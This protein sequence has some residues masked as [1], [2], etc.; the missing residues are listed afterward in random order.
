MRVEEIA[1]VIVTE[2][3]SLIIVQFAHCTTWEFSIAIRVPNAGAN[4]C[5]F[6]SRINVAPGGGRIFLALEQRRELAAA[7]EQVWLDRPAEGY[8]LERPPNW[9]QAQRQALRDMVDQQGG[10]T[11]ALLRHIRQSR[12]SPLVSIDTIKRYVKK[13][14][15]AASAVG[16]AQK[17]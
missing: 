13:W 14:K 16:M 8:H 3:T 4:D 6:G 2:L 15:C 9:N 11:G 1:S 5:S 17:T 7:V 12:H 10:T